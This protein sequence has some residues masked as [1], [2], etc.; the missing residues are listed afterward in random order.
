MIEAVPPG[1]RLVGRDGELLVLVGRR[2]QKV[3]DLDLRVD[4]AAAGA[5]AAELLVGDVLAGGVV[6]GGDVFVVVIVAAAA[7]RRRFRSAGE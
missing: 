4:V 2:R 3:S 1:G 7:A 6:V 5:A